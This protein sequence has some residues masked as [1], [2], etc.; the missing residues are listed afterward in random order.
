M[1]SVSKELFECK[2]AMKVWFNIFLH[3]HEDDK[4]EIAKSYAGMSLISQ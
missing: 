3:F 2:F 1:V 4:I